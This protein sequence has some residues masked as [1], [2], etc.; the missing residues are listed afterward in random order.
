MSLW[1]WWPWKQCQPQGCAIITFYSVSAKVSSYERNDSKKRIYYYL[2][3]TEKNALLKSKDMW[4]RAC[5]GNL[6]HTHKWGT[7]WGI[8]EEHVDGIRSSTN[9]L[10]REDFNKREDTSGKKEYCKKNWWPQ[11]YFLN[12]TNFSKNFKGILWLR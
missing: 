10:S 3:H 5:L 11:N 1:R 2:K 8:V 9:S 12:L 4:A 6:S 7:H